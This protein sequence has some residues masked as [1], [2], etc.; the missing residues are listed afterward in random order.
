MASEVKLE[1]IDGKIVPF[2]NGTAAHS[3]VCAR[4]VRFLRR[5]AQPG[6]GVFTSKFGLRCPSGS[7]YVFPDV[8]Y[9][10]ENPEPDETIA[11][12]RLIIEVMSPL[13]VERDR[14]D[15]VD[16]YLGIPTIEEYL[17]IDSRRPWAGVY[18]RSD[19]GWTYTSYGDGD[20]IEFGAIG[21]GRVNLSAL[22][23]PEPD[24]P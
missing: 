10:C 14:V 8:T 20:T 17:V 6:C 19:R 24:E 18:R 7:T 1:L 12:P 4:V 22:Y 9:T 13:S 11:P 23:A 3:L 5:I 16:I 21:G 15:K 2:A